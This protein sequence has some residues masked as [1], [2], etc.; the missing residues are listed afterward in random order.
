[1][2][3]TSGFTIIEALLAMLVLSVGLLGAAAML[4]GALRDQGLALR[5]LVAT[6]MV[7]EFAERLRIGGAPTADL[8]AEFSAA[9]RARFPAQTPDT[10]ITVAP[11]TGGAA[12]TE[13]RITL[14]WLDA[15]ATD[16]MA[17]VTTVVVA[18]MPVAG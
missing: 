3:R 10:L 8:L 12:T 16:S 2:R 4:L 5:H 15:A 18:Q 17:E 14:R 13:Y 6:A 1:M 9:A 11:A 7:T